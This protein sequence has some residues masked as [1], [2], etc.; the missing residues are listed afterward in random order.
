MPTVSVDKGHLVPHTIAI[1][2]ARG[3]SVGIPRKNL[4]PIAGRPLV[5]HTIEHA[6]AAESVDRVV[7]STDDND[8]AAVSRAAGAEVVMRPAEISGGEASSESALSHALGELLSLGDCD[9]ELVVFL[10]AT[11]PFRRPDDIDRAVDTLRQQDADSLF[12]AC[13]TH[14]FVWRRGPSPEDQGNSLRALTYDPAHRPRR[15]DIGE[16][17]M[18]NGSIYVFKP[19]VLRE[20]DNRLGGRIAVHVMDPLDSFQIDE[21]SDLA[22]AEA[23]A[24]LRRT[25]HVPDFSVIRL[26]VLDFDGVMTDNRVIVRQ[27]AIESVMCDRSDGMGLERARDRGLNILIIS[28]ERNP[29]VSARAGKLKIEVYQ[30]IDNKL[31]TLQRL[32]EERGFAQHD[33]AYVGNDIND[34][35][36]MSWVGLGIAVADAYPEAHEVADWVTSKPGGHGAVREVCDLWISARENSRE[37]TKETRS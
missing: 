27:D 12:S 3:G 7:V 33:I 11:S 23:L 26:L 17:L 5:V 6:L 19:A 30:Q 18:E 22:V 31:P 4:T 24:P 25:R 16:D 20:H 32:A 36:C 37:H 34:L 9:P 21:P 28:K 13:P 2:P 35:E 14:G 29:V 15:Q 8:I 1:I 10:Q